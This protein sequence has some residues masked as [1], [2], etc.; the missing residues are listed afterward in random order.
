[1]PGLYRV[2]VPNGAFATGADWVVITLFSST[3][4]MFRATFA[5]EDNYHNQTADAV[6]KR[7]W[8]VVSGEAARSTLNALRV[9]RNAHSTSGSV[10]TVTKE[11]DV[12]A[13]FTIA[14][15]TNAAALPITGGDP[16]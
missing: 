11:D 6:L 4:L 16:S 12:S 1:M 10:I 7:D 9:L 3:S 8:T 13:A 14:I 5:I 2:D 15:T